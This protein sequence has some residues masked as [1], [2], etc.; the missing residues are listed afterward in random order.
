MRAASYSEFGSAQDV[1]KLGEVETPVP[2]E[3]CVR[4]R[5]ATSGVNPSDTKQ[6]G[7]VVKRP[8][9]FPVIP[10]SDGA[11]IIDEV[12]PG[13]PES[14]IGERVWVYNA[15]FMRSNGTSAQYVSL[16][17]DCV[18]KLPDNTDFAAGACFGIPAVTAYRAV[19]LFGPI[20][21]LTVLVQAQLVIL[22]SGLTF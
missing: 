18:V 11:G 13:V 7:A 5:L 19:T 9:K 8:V 1:L 3:G 20:E 10:H 21:G 17:N 22:Q 14:R 12:G 4:V 16:P 6:R 2:D 15:Q